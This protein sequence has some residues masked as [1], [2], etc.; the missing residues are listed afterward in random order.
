MLKLQYAEHRARHRRFD[1]SLHRSVPPGMTIFIARP[2]ARVCQTRHVSETPGPSTG[3]T[4]SDNDGDANT[5]RK[6]VTG[7]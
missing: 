7:P 2:F 6:V 3:V 1:L 4:A 5:V